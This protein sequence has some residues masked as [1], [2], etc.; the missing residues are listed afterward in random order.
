MSLA[1]FV[2]ATAIIAVALSILMSI[3]W[4]VQQRTGNSGW[5]DAIWTFGTGGVG[6][7][8][9]LVPLSQSLP[10]R[11]ILVAGLVALWALRLGSYISFRSRGVGDDPRYRH[12][13]EAWGADAPRQMFVLLQKQAIV[14]VPLALAILLAAHNPQP[15]LG[16]QDMLGVAILAVAIAGEKRADDQLRRFKAEPGNRNAVCDVGLWRW[17]RHPNYFFEWLGWC[18]YPLLAIDL[19]GANPLGWL[20]LIA[21]ACMYWLLVHV[22]GV[23]P[24]EAHMLRSRGNAFRAY[25]RRTRT[26]F[27]FPLI[28][29]N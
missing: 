12:M 29:R 20:S 24:L 26:F 1:Q 17:S 5:V 28:S 10:A 22:S 23:P 13:A 19:S 3:A 6:A 16:L 8:A 9:A 14:S 27:P 7:V 25:Q 2:V 15:Q 4:L 18:A 11:Q 21:P